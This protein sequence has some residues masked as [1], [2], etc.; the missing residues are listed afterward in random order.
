MS[1][2]G[3]TPQA[4]D[5][6]LHW[7]VCQAGYVFTQAVWGDHSLT[8]AWPLVDPLFRR[9]W[10]QGWLQD[11][12]DLTRAC[13]FDPDEVVEAFT[14]ECPEHPLWPEFERLQLEALHGWKQDVHEWGA[15]AEHK[16]VGVDLEL[17][18]MLPRPESGNVVAEG[19]PFVPLLMRY[20]VEAGWRVLNCVSEHVPVPGWPP[21]LRGES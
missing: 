8:D 21:Q 18:Y 17:L 9:C 7:P 11:Q 10:A 1:L 4:L 5:D 15:T 16:L 13:G 14:A 12:R 6:F 20:D 2:D 3:I 19:S